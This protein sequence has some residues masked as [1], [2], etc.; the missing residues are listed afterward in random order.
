MAIH[1][2]FPSDAV[3]LEPAKPAPVV[4]QVDEVEVISPPA[5]DFQPHS[6]GAAELVRYQSFR[7][8]TSE[9]VA[10]KFPAKRSRT[11]EDGGQETSSPKPRLPLRSSS[12]GAQGNQRNPRC[13][14]PWKGR[15]EMQLPCFRS[16][17]IATSDPSYLRGTPADVGRGRIS[18]RDGKEQVT[19]SAEQSSGSTSTEPT[20]KENDIRGVVP[21]LTPP[22]EGDIKWDT[23]LNQDPAQTTYTASTEQSTTQNASTTGPQSNQATNRPSS[24]EIPSSG[25]MDQQPHNSGPVS[26]LDRA[27]ELVGRHN[28]T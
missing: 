9:N 22:E 3:L 11:N 5:E 20:Q 6:H 28:V 12:F 4:V 26:G 10:T 17:G 24:I 27:V 8:E 1:D 18:R 13:E 16:L 23:N 2:T 19:G 14:S 25:N 15:L 21:L 7:V